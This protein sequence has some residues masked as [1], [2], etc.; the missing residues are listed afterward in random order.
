V[1][2]SVDQLDTS[3]ETVAGGLA[4]LL[5]HLL[6]STNRDFFSALESAGISLTQMKCL[7]LLYDAGEP[8]PLGSLSAEIG[9]SPPA[10]SRAVDGLVQRGEV[11]RTEDPSDRRAKR[12][13]VSARGRRTFER[14]VEIR[15][16]GVRRF[17]STLSEHEREALASSIGPLVERLRP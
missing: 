8:L 16:A 17:V 3:V 12:L 9:L 10:V 5:K 14:L 11:K 13:T 1:Q 2:A 6:G 15:F 7:G 4:A